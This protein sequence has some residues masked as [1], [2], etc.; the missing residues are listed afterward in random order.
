M[1]RHEINEAMNL[2]RRKMFSITGTADTIELMACPAQVK[3]KARSI[4][5]AGHELIDEM[6]VLLG[7]PT[8]PE[9]RGNVAEAT[10]RAMASTPPSKHDSHLGRTGAE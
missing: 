6:A 4:S 8:N 5:R 2:L 1:T 3:A 9:I 7:A 10:E